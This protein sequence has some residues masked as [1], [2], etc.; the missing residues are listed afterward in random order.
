MAFSL[1]SF[2]LQ[3]SGWRTLRC[4]LR[5][6]SCAL[7]SALALPHAPSF[8]SPQAAS[9]PTDEGSGTG[10]CR[11]SKPRRSFFRRLSGS[12]S[13]S[14]APESGKRAS[15]SPRQRIMRLVTRSATPSAAPSPKEAVRRTAFLMSALPCLTLPA[16]RPF[17]INSMA[18]HHDVPSPCACRAPL[19][20]FFFGVLPRSLESAGDRSQHTGASA[21]EG[22]SEARKSRFARLGLLDPSRRASSSSNSSSSSS[23]SSSSSGPGKGRAGR[24]MSPGSLLRPSKAAPPA[25]ASSS[26]TSSSTAVSAA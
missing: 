11:G 6:V 22:K 26:T 18:I 17:S 8:A 15:L 21:A 1:P 7:P 3:R 2:V 24:S 12:S 23:T 5:G 19:R 9:S 16:L 14:T 20:C 10:S 4:S 25:A 13:G